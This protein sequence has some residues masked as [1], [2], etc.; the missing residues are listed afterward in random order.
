MYTGS[1]PVPAIFYLPAG[2]AHRLNA[3][4]CTDLKR[5]TVKMMYAMVCKQLRKEDDRF[6]SCREP[7]FVMPASAKQIIPQQKESV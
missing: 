5:R 4:I 7:Y 3:P 6:W 1:N 2:E